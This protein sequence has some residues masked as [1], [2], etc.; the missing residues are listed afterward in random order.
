MSTFSKWTLDGNNSKSFQI[1]ESKSLQIRVDA[2]NI[3]NHPWPADPIG[4]GA[5]G[6]NFSSD[7]FGQITS[8]G[9]NVNNLPR[10]FQGKLRFSF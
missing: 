1:S 4:L 10:T 9:G 2:V 3:L 7:N 5:T 6:T 8:K